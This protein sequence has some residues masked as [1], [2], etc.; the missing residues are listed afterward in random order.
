MKTIIRNEVI[1]SNSTRSTRLA[2]ARQVWSNGL[3]LRLLSTV[4]PPF[5]KGGEPNLGGTVTLS[6]LAL[7]SSEMSLESLN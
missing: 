3:I 5:A 4:S 6:A 7:S 1:T 2:R